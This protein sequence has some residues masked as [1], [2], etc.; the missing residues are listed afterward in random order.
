MCFGGRFLNF[1]AARRPLDFPNRLGWAA[2]IAFG[3][4]SG[5][6][7]PTVHGLRQVADCKARLPPAGLR[8]RAMRAGRATQI[9][10]RPTRTNDIRA[11]FL[12]FFAKND[13]AVVP[14]A[15]SCRATIRL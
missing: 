6:V 3:D 4:A 15:R 1:G 13:H 11:A 5:P 7:K 14:S 12:D 9:G 2:P 10:A 8:A